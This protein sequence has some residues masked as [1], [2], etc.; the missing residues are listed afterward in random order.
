MTAVLFDLD[1][2]L[3]DSLGGITRA[4]NGV[5]ADAGL[6]AIG[7]DLTVGFVGRGERYFVR[8]LI[9]ETGLDPDRFDDHLASFLGH[10]EVAARVTP[11]MP[12]ARAALDV[13]KASGYPLGLVTNKPRRP[14]GPTLAA[15]GLTKDFDV[16]LAGD[17]LERRKPDPLPLFEAV[18]QLGVASG[19]YVGDS[20]IDGATAQAAKMPFVLYTRGIRTVPVEEIP[21][22]VAFDDFA[23][24]PE[25]VAKLAG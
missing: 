2:T 16:V 1:G 17:D 25:I 15:A 3:I 19:I 14:L 12:G 23:E 6:P 11:L 13:L 18:S 7:E 22:V 21:H 10:Y 8:R 5:L 20:D 4:A 24:L 9:E